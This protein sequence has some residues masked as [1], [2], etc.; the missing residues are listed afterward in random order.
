[1]MDLMIK[2]CKRLREYLNFYEDDGVRVSKSNV[3]KSLEVFLYFL[4]FCY[5]FYI[6]FCEIFFYFFIC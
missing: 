6:N 1:M 2:I 3:F 5:S 4:C